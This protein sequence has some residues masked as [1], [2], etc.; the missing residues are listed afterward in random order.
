[1]FDLYDGLFC[2]F[3]KIKQTVSLLQMKGRIEKG[4]SSAFFHFI[5]SQK[6]IFK[7]WR[8][9]KTITFLF[10]FPRPFLAFFFVQIHSQG[11]SEIEY[12]RNSFRSH[13]IH[14]WC[15]KHKRQKKLRGFFGK[16]MWTSGS[17]TYLYSFVGNRL[18]FWYYP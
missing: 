3:M 13:R 4:K 16:R 15:Q 2:I 5:C 12:S 6:T 9:N 7:Y 18:W 14:K 10:L 11:Q 8:E 17:E 1:M